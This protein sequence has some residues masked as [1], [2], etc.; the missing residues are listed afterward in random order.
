[1]NREDNLVHINM[2][3]VDKDAPNFISHYEGVSIHI[4]PHVL[5][6]IVRISLMQMQMVSR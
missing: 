3:L 5:T 4:T 2:A 1:M 6:R